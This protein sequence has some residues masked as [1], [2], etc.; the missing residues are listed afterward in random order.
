MVEPAAAPEAASVYNSATNEWTLQ[1]DVPQRWP[2]DVTSTA[3]TIM[4]PNATIT[5][6]TGPSGATALDFGLPTSLLAPPLGFQG[7]QGPAVSGPSGPPGWPAPLNVTG[8]QG[9]QGFLGPQGPLNVPLTWAITTS[10]DQTIQSGGPQTLVE[11]DPLLSVVPPG[12]TDHLGPGPTYTYWEVPYT[13]LWRIAGTVV[14][15]ASKGGDPQ[16]TTDLV[17][18]GLLAPSYANTL[19]NS[20][21]LQE[22]PVSGSAV[23]TPKS[24]CYTLPNV[25]VG[26]QWTLFANATSGNEVAMTVAL[27]SQLTFT[28]LGPTVLAP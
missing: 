7:R 10:T 23:S 1:V 21:V 18:E 17:L 26:S 15:L 5:V 16:A 28:Y 11:W 19:F 12:E 20:N 24:I 13:G 6:V 8:F 22:D 14:T 2:L 4:G 3:S 25:P 9:P 27:G